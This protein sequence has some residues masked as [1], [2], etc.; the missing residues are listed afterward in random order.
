VL[1]RRRADMPRAVPRP[2][3]STRAEQGGRANPW[4]R[5][6]PC[7]PPRPASRALASLRVSDRFKMGASQMIGGDATKASMD[8][9]QVKLPH[10]AQEGVVKSMA[11]VSLRQTHAPQHQRP[12]LGNVYSP[13]PAPGSTISVVRKKILKRQENAA[14]SEQAAE[15]LMESPVA[16]RV[17]TAG[18][19]S[20]RF[21]DNDRGGDTRPRGL[22]N[23]EED[24]YGIT[25]GMVGE[26][27][28]AQWRRQFWQKNTPWGVDRSLFGGGHFYETTIKSSVRNYNNS[29]RWEHDPKLV[30]T[31]NSEDIIRQIVYKL[32]Q[33]C[34]TTFA[35]TRA[36]KIFDRDM[37]SSIDKV[38]VCMSIFAFALCF[39]ECFLCKRRPSPAAT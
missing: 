24:N 6:L 19:N 11:Q 10:A 1:R 5:F 36:F 25:R 30:P 15:S 38:R 14:R 22:P 21:V 2:E 4:I 34:N 17:S 7:C 31:G 16:P 18:S 12:A 3:S 13:T 39:A 8:A 35:L 27:P 26:T 23:G 32:E 9:S 28:R 33:H 29:T 20:V 37:S